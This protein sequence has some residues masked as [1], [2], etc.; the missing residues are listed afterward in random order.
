LDVL[1]PETH[2]LSY[3]QAR[4]R[5]R[6]QALRQSDVPIE[7]AVSLPLPTRR[8]GD[9]GYAQFAAPCSRAPDRPTVQ[10]PPDR[11]WVFDAKSGHL[12][13]YALTS[14]IAFPADSASQFTSVELLP[15]KESI[16]AMRDSLAVLDTVMEHIVRDFFHGH[17][18]DPEARRHVA[19]LL[20]AV[21]PTALIPRYRALVPD[22]FV[23]LD[24]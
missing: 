21:V 23:W 13:V 22:F 9:G 17:P 20:S 16:A 18:G 19:A 15:M 6:S 8:W 5:Q 10:S 3:A 1:L 12:I 4:E 14:A 2:W 7:H 24:A 11:W